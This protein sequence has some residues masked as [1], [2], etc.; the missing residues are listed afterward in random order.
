MHIYL[1]LIGPQLEAG[2]KIREAHELTRRSVM[3]VSWAANYT[4]DVWDQNNAACWETVICRIKGNAVVAKGFSLDGRCNL[5]AILLS[6]ESDGLLLCVSG[7]FK[8]SFPFCKQ[9]LLVC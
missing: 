7:C 9:P 5:P 3:R 2:I 6:S 8:F 4:E 1:F